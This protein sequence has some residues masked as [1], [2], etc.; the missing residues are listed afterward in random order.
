VSSATA[1]FVTPVQS[2]NFSDRVGSV[3]ALIEPVPAATS[4]VPSPLSVIAPPE[5]YPV[6]W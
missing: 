4:M 1:W 2:K 6:E 3:V 5:K